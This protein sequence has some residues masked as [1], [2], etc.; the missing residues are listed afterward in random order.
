L[1]RQL[2]NVDTPAACGV[3][4]AR[5]K[6]A[7]GEAAGALTMLAEAEQF[8]QQYHFDQWIGEI[9]AVR[10]QTYLNQGNLAAAAQLAETHD[11]PL[12]QARVHL[13]QGHPDAALAVLEPVRQQAEAKA[14]GDQRLQAMVLQAL[15]YD[16]A[17][18]SEKAAQLL[19]EVLALSAPGG[20]LRLFIDE[21]APMARLLYDALA[22]GVEP[23]TIRQLL[24]AF[25]AADAEQTPS[26][27]PP[28]VE[29][30]FVE[31]LSEREIEVLQLIAEGLTNQE[32]A[33]QLYLS[34]HT[35]KVHAR[36]IYSKLDVKNRTQAVAKAKALGIL[37][38]T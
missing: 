35:V 8:V 12:S 26:S 34:L 21:G 13:A 28:I 6:L 27:K 37:P 9:T 1:A 33:N 7:Q 5:V 32:V 10:I 20:L 11:L 2:E 16:A 22:L 29:T 25:P 17:G 3:L 19:G 38:P 36:N 4:L 31:P 30:G 24:A 14:W 15:A 23:R 18:E